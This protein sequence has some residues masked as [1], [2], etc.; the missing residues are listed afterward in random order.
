M[1][2]A[3]GT[4]LLTAAAIV[5][6]VSFADDEALKKRK[7]GLKEADVLTQFGD[8]FLAAKRDDPLA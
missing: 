6:A 4:T 5:S 2:A 8:R 1:G 7:L 3:G